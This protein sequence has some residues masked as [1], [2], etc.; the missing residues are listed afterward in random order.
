VF[1]Q[2]RSAPI[3]KAVCDGPIRRTRSSAPAS[4]EA[5]VTKFMTLMVEATRFSA[6]SWPIF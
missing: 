5:L 3:A 2:I 6:K 4:D 1:D